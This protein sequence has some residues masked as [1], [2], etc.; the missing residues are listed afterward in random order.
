MGLTSFEEDEFEGLKLYTCFGKKF[1]I[2][3]L[4]KER[5]CRA[6]TRPVSFDTSRVPWAGE[7]LR[8]IFFITCPIPIFPSTISLD[9]MMSVP[10]PMLRIL[11]QS[12]VNQSVE[13]YD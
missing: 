3:R 11:N 4:G 13:F 1:E 8:T 7:F 5:L 10:N 9:M 6:R 2:A 12:K